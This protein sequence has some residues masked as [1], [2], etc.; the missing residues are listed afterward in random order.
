MMDL[1]MKATSFGV[2][3]PLD[4]ECAWDGRNCL[5]YYD[6]AT[7][8]ASAKIFRGVM[9]PDGSITTPGNDPKTPSN[10]MLDVRNVVEELPSG[11]YRPTGGWPYWHFKDASGT[12]RPIKELK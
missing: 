6:P 10:A 11:T 9:Y 2:S 3:F 5:S 8:P 12:L 7:L 4:V 1:S